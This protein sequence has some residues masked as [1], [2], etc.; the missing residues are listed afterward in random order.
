ME[1]KVIKYPTEAELREC[2]F[3]GFRMPLIYRYDPFYGYQGDLSSYKVV[4]GNCS[5]TI[6]RRKEQE[7]IEAWNRRY[8][9]EEI[10]FDYGAE[11]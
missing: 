7:A 10:D 3:C 2:P 8:T 4:C 1:V 11:D 9:P 6:K 5:A